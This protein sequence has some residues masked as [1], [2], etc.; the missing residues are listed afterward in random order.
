[1]RHTPG[2]VTPVPRTAP[3]AVT[4]SL[5]IRRG[6]PP[7]ADALSGS[8]SDIDPETSGRAPRARPT[9]SAAPWAAVHPRAPGAPAAHARAVEA[10]ACSQRRAVGP[11]Q[12][13]GATLTPLVPATTSG[14]VASSSRASRTV[15]ERPTRASRA[16]RR[17]L[18]VVG[19]VGGDH[20]DHAD[21]EV[22]R[23]L[24]VAPTAPTRGPARARR[25]AAA[26][27]TPGRRPRPGP[28][29]ARGRRWPPA[30]RP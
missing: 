17:A 10:R 19:H 30:R 23:V 20:R 21:A 5:P 11:V 12:P 1:M 3:R 7:S 22:E 28:A 18:D 29:A 27:T 24:Q 13:H 9:C 6:D 14:A 2:V 15:P 26:P 4:R 16:P 8:R 25:P